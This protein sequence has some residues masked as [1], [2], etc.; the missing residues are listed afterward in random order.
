MKAFKKWQNKRTIKVIGLLT[1]QGFC[2]HGEKEGWRAALE[3]IRDHPDL[4]D[5]FCMTDVINKELEDK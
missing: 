2:R 3:W 4:D 5:P 1:H